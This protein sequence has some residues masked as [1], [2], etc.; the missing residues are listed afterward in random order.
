MGFA[1]FFAKFLPYLM[2]FQSSAAPSLH[3]T[4]KNHQIWQKMKKGFVLLAFNLFLHDNVGTRN[5]GFGYLPVPQLVNSSPIFFFKT[6]TLLYFKSLYAFLLLLLQQQCRKSYVV[7]CKTDRYLD[8]VEI[9]SG[10]S[11]QI[12]LGSALILIQKINISCF[13]FLKWP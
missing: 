4:L 13:K 2:I 5:P 12:K 1:S 8:Q 11:Y 6:D 3:S 9:L 7:L 10:I